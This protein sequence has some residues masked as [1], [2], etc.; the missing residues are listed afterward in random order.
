MATYKKGRLL[1]LLFIFLGCHATAQ[2]LDNFTASNTG[3]GVSP[4]SLGPIELAYMRVHKSKI[5]V[6]EWD[7]H[8]DK[9]YIKTNKESTITDFAYKIAED[10]FAQYWLPFNEIK[11]ISAI[12]FDTNSEGKELWIEG[13]ITVTD[14]VLKKTTGGITLIAATRTPIQYI[15]F[16]NYY[17]EEQLKGRKRAKH[18]SRKVKIKGTSLV[19]RGKPYS[20]KRGFN[21]ELTFIDKGTYSFRN[22]YFLKTR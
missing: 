8:N 7:I 2:T 12:E 9:W 4:D 19:V 17:K 15:K 3:W 18:Y 21:C 22:Y 5:N 13:V 11:K 14:S 16:Y 1:L 10:T 20:Y 6:D